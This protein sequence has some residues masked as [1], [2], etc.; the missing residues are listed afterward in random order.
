MFGKLLNKEKKR[1]AKERKAALD[2]LSQEHR[3]YLKMQDENKEAAENLVKDFMKNLNAMGF[4]QTPIIRHFDP[5]QPGI[6]GADVIF[7]KLSYPLYRKAMGLPPEGESEKPVGEGENTEETAKVE[8]ENGNTATP[9]E[10]GECCDNGTF[11]DGHECQKQE[12]KEEYEGGSSTRLT[13]S[14]WE[15]WSPSSTSAKDTRLR[16]SF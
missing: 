1:Q 3:D 15:Q 7:T 2:A 5:N 10:G 16:G 9:A 13:T 14:L 12:E 8:G 4:V 6:V 11:G